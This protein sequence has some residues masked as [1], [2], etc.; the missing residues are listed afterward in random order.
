MPVVQSSVAQRGV[1]ELVELVAVAVVVGSALEED[2][3][4]ERNEKVVMRVVA[5]FVVEIVVVM[6][7]V[8]EENLVVEQGGCE[9]CLGAACLGVDRTLDVS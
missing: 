6:L 1:S 4:L 7:A 9:V 2:L 8:A 5:M 3:L